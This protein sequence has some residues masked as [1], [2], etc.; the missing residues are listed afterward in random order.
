MIETG[1]MATQSNCRFSLYTYNRQQRWS[2]PLKI[3]SLLRNKVHARWLRV[4]TP[5]RVRTGSLRSRLTADKPDGTRPALPDISMLS[6]ELQQQWHVDLNMHLGAIRV[7]PHSSIRAVWQCDKCPAGQPH[8]WTASVTSRSYGTDCPYCKGRRVCLHNS[9]AAIAPEAAKYWNH[10]KNEKPPEETLAG[11]QYRA[12][13]RCPACKHEWQARV[14][15]R[16]R[17]K[18][19]LSGCPKC[20]SR[21][22]WKSQPTFAEAKPP[23]LAEW[24]HERNETEGIFSHKVTLGSGKLVHWICLRCPRGQPHRWTAQPLKRISNGTGCAVCAGKQACVCNSLESLVPSVAAEF[25]VDKNDF[26]PSEVTAQSHKE[27]W[28]RNA[29]RGSWRQT[30]SSR[31]YY[32]LDP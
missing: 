26:A 32:R 25:D 14:D 5:A 2:L 12:E 22:T 13:W 24:D 29:E 3:A 11:C 23:E 1:Q 15:S 10:N 7:K 19:A 27:V 20:I 31:T 9:L 6:P 8:V 21:K 30:I 28:W 18:A 16:T 4:E 17:K